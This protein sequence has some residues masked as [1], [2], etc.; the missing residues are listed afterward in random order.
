MEHAS[1]QQQ[2]VSAHALRHVVSSSATCAFECACFLHVVNRQVWLVLL[3]MEAGQL[4][5]MGQV[6]GVRV[7]QQQQQGVRV[8]LGL[9][10]CIAANFVN[11]TTATAA[12]L[13]RLK[14]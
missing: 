13:D 8:V 4:L 7:Q 1:K 6:W 3:I 10:E 9:G 2:V 5:A 11:E 14:E 12:K